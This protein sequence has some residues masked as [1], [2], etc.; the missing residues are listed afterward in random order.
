MLNKC[1]ALASEPAANLAG[2][3]VSHSVTE[4]FQA[5]SIRK[6]PA[7]RRKSESGTCATEE[8]QLTR[9][10]QTLRSME[11]K[12]CRILSTDTKLHLGVS[13]KLQGCRENRFYRTQLQFGIRACFPK[14][15]VE[16]V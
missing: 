4:V 15:C 16:S 12:L 14:I 3:Y 8:V 1:Q 5:M 7:I 10:P 2:W 6:D 9:C 13:P 11:H